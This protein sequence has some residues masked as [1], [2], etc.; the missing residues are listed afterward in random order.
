LSERRYIGTSFTVSE[1][2]PITREEQQK[3]EAMAMRRDERSLLTGLRST[4]ERLPNKGRG[5]GH[6]AGEVEA[7][8]SVQPG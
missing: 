3:E 2:V 7:V 8:G 1:A 6:A 4:E 5:A